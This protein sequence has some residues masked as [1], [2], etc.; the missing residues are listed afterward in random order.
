MSRRNRTSCGPAGRIMTWIVKGAKRMRLGRNPGRVD[1]RRDV[2]SGV[3]IR[4]Y[5]ELWNPELVSWGRPGPGGGGK[6]WG[7]V[8]LPYGRTRTNV[9]EQRGMYVLHHEWRVVYVGKT[10]GNDL[11]A[12]IKHHLS[13]PLA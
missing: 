1:V 12:R 6:M 10:E 13:D 11:G 7:R 5:G 3:L 4:A 9:W 2:V 8:R